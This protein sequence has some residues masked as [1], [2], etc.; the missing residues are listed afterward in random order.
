MTLVLKDDEPVYQSAKRLAALERAE[1]NTQISEWVEDGIV[2]HAV[3]DYASLVVLVAKKDG[4]KRL[5]LDYLLL[6]KNI[7]KDRYSLLLIE[8]QLEKL[9][10]A[11]VFRKLDLKNRFFHEP[12]DESSQKYTA[13][14][15]HFFLVVSFFLLI[16]NLLMHQS[17]II[18]TSYDFSYIRVC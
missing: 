10:D 12:V 14:G 18:Y 6:N 5:C 4:S 13:F 16:L 3:S 17:N 2:R 11:R 9:Q 8:D 15:W 1:I 7:I